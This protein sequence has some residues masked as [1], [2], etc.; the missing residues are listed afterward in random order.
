MASPACWY[1]AGQTLWAGLGILAALWYAQCWRRSR[2]LPALVL[3]GVSAALA[4]W[5]WTI[6]HLA[7]PVAAVYLWADGRRHCR[8]AA[9]VPLLATGWPWP[10]P[11]PWEAARSTPRSASTAARPLRRTPRPGHPAHLPGDPR[12]PHPRKP[13]RPGRTTPSQGVI[14]TLM[15]VAIWAAARWRQGGLRAFNPLE[16]RGPGARAGQ[17][18]RRV[19]LPW[20]PAVLV[21]ED[22]Q[23]GHDRPLVRRHPADRGNP[24]HHGL[25]LGSSTRP[26]QAAPCP[27][28]TGV[29]CLAAA[30]V[31]GL[32]AAAIA[33]NGPRVDLLWRAWVPPLPPAE[34][35]MFRIRE[36]RSLRHD[37][38]DLPRRSGKGGTCDGSTGP[39][40]GP[41]RG[42]RPRRDPLRFRPPGHA[43]TPRGLRRR[44]PA[45]RP[46]RGRL[47][48]RTR[49]ARPSVRMS[50]W[51]RNRGRGGYRPNNPGP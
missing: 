31:L 50:S 26:G 40:N 51:N 37:P 41:S 49:F 1:S 29:T 35:E 21:P 23:S 30:G 25:D 45:G 10:L 6:G 46:E 2:S 4:G 3:A 15:I 8:W 34:Q 43:R 16:V 13:R 22:P 20:L 28:R 33:L 17:L 18:P 19:D 5:F 44:G 7:G 36:L 32:M 38:A 27:T 11:W 9:A 12:E 14:L 42:D 24:L 39:R 47:P 48:I